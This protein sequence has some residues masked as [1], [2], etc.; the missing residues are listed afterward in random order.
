MLRVLYIA[1]YL[2]T[3][4]NEMSSFVSAAQNKEEAPAATASNN[5]KNVKRESEGEEE[6]NQPKKISCIWHPRLL[7]GSLH[8]NTLY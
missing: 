5:E 7:P 6:K 4:F 1:Q 3:A 2:Y 8:Y